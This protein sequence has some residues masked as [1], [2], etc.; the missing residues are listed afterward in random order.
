LHFFKSLPLICTNRTQE[1]AGNEQKIIGKWLALRAPSVFK[2]QKAKYLKHLDNSL[3]PVSKT[4]AVRMA[5]FATGVVDTR[6]AP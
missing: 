5:K 6:D 3:P 1:N 4:P 2:K